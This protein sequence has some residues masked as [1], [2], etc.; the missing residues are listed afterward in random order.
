[1][2][3]LPLVLAIGVGA[4]EATSAL[5][6][7]PATYYVSTGGND[8][9]AGTSTA[10]PWRTINRV[11]SQALHAGD[12][13]LFQG[14][15][16]FAGKLYVNP[17]EKGTPTAP[18]SF[19][20]YGSGRATLSGGTGSAV[21]VYDV[22]GVVFQNL[23]LTGSGASS[24]TAEG[25]SL[26]NDL[27]GNVKLPYVR[28]TNVSVSG[29]GHYGIS[30]G[31]WNGTSG[32]QDV[33]VTYSDS[34]DNGRGGISTYGPSFQPS[35]PAYANANVYIGHVNVYSNSGDPKLAGNS[36]NGIV[37]GSVQ[38]ATIERSEAHDN[39]L[40]CIASQCGA[41]IWTYDSTAVTIQHNESYHNRTG[42]PTDGDGFDLDQNVSN[43]TLQYNYSHDNDGAG[44]LLYTGQSNS[45]WTGN[46]VRYNI[47][48]N[49]GRKNGYAAVFAGGKVYSS[50]IYDNTVYESLP[51]SGRPPAIRFLSLGS[52]MT[53]RNNIFYAVGGLPM[54]VSPAVSTSALVFQQN[55]YYSPSAQFSVN[56]GSTTYTSL[57]SW[58]TATGQE[59]L[60]GNVTGFAVNPQLVNAGGGGTIGNADNLASL[61][62]YKLQPSTPLLDKGLD[63]HALFGISTG[64]VDYYGVPVPSHAGPDVGA[65]EVP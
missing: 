54:V 12:T 32:Y 33:Q 58:Q 18:I 26:Y 15:G 40:S 45:A 28:I 47:T 7:T 34:H 42:G 23:V 19:G 27:S 55:D 30:I 5:A 57:G 50:A 22:G 36:G 56:W 62:A 35:A 13:V 24:N 29:F 4:A 63:L 1:L 11:N 38:G 65:S 3:A 64:G 20:S 60:N 6:A 10:H 17:N 31:G 21:L 61:T 52:G 9:A 41:G 44:Y 43:S 53:V 14:G 39:G 46:A 51:P 8:S 59:K 49:D 37:L 2:L 25:L 16:T 48:Q